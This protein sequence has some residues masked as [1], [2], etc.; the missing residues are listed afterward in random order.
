MH[1]QRQRRS[2]ALEPGQPGRPREYDPGEADPHG[3]APK[4]T[5]RFEPQVLEWIREQGG[6]TWVR[7]AAKELMELSAEPEFEDWWLRLQ[8]PEE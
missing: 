7:H 6:A 8:L 4:I 1:Y 5:I 2:G 3:G